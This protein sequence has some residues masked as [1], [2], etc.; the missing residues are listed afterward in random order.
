VGWLTPVARA[1]PIRLPCSSAAKKEGMSAQL[2]L[3][4]FMNEWLVFGFMQ[5]CDGSEL[6]TIVFTPF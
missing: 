3:V 4:V 5:L 2:K 1:A 6:K